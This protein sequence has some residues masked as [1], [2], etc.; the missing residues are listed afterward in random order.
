MS[1]R[2]HRFLF[3]NTVLHIPDGRRAG[4][5]MNITIPGKEC[6]VALWSIKVWYKLVK[7]VAQNSTSGT[8]TPNLDTFV[9]PAPLARDIVI[10]IGTSSQSACQPR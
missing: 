2:R 5:A 10:S 8:Y 3:L 6:L 7:L 4:W 1:C 9:S